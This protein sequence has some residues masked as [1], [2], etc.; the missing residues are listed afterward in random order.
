MLDSCKQ[1]TQTLLVSDT[2]QSTECT[3]AEK[4]DKAAAFVELPVYLGEPNINKT[5]SK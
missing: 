2:E 3:M 1:M 4:M 5:I